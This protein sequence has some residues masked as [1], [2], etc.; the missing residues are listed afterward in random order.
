M[1]VGF[2]ELADGVDSVN[3][4]NEDAHGEQKGGV[5][6]EFVE[7]TDGEQVHDEQL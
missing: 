1:E 3:H 4:H 5:E 6:F 7:I 2:G